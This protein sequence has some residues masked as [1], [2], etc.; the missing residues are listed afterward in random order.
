ME[1]E[2]QKRNDWALLSML[3][4]FRFL[5]TERLQVIRN[6][7]TCLKLLGRQ[8]LQENIQ[9][10]PG[11]GFRTGFALQAELW[12]MNRF[13]SNDHLNSYVGLA[14]HTFGSGEDVI[15]KCGNRKKKQLHNLMI[16]AAWRAI[17]HN[18]EYK[19][20]YGALLGRGMSSQKAIVVIAKKL[21]ETV[22]AVW[23]QD[24]K[25]INF[26]EASKVK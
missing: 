15:V 12:D 7:R 21:M 26:L 8:K 5:R 17:R 14:P 19:A 4:E 10:V 18:L 25:Y 2:A 24:R 20:R 3:R 23:L 16:E 22:R 9:S 1:E 13:K 11:F 6:Q